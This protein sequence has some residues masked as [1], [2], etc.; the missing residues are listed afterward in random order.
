M[1]KQPGDGQVYF[2]CFS[3]ILT[4]F[5]KSPTITPLPAVSRANYSRG[6]FRRSARNNISS[7]VSQAGSW[8]PPRKYPGLTSRTS[9]IWFSVAATGWWPCRIRDMVAQE[10]PAVWRSWAG[11][12]QRSPKAGFYLKASWNHQL[13]GPHLG[14]FIF[15]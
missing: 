8:Y 10:M 1:K 15:F 7:S 2:L 4:S 13:K 11:V 3:I 14:A 12:I 5:S 6:A 9:A